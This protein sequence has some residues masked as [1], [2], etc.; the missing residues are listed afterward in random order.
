VVALLDND[1]IQGTT[2]HK[3]GKLTKIKKKRKEKKHACVNKNL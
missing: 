3:E 2:Q 1:K